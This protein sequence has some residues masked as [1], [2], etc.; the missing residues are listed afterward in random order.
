[1]SFQNYVESGAPLLTGTDSKLVGQFTLTNT[2]HTVANTLRRCIISDTRSVGFTAEPLIRKNTSVVFNEM[3]AHRIHLIPLGV[4]NIDSFDP[5]KYQCELRIS[6]TQKTNIREDSLLH[7]KAGDFRVLEKQ[8][9]G[10]FVDVGPA[11]SQSMFPP[12]PITGDTCLIVTL[13]PHWNPDQPSE[14]LDITAY[15]VIGTAHTQNHI[16]FSPVSQCTYA[17]TPDTNPARREQFF[18]EWLAIAKKAKEGDAVLPEHYQEWETLD[19][20]RCFLVNEKGEPYS[21]DFT[22]ESVGVRPVPEIV[23]EGI[24]AVVQ[25][26]TPYADSVQTLE[27]LK[28]TTRPSN[29]RMENAIDLL[30]EGQDHTLGNLLQRVMSDSFMGPTGDAGSPLTFVGYKVPHPLIKSMTIRLQFKNDVPITEDN[31]KEMIHKAAAKAREQFADLGRE[32]ATVSRP[33]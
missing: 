20:K 25:L 29:N 19:A 7:V 30:F 33:M 18:K 11:A 1:M 31:V 32:W 9:D 10:G 8:P 24:Q 17:N 15:P 6:N 5:S 4:R 27:S 28:I 26:L 12:D 13:K 16:S 22:I 2:N 14:E 3:L 23:A 21:F